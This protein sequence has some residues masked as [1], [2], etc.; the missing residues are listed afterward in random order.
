MTTAPCKN[1]TERTVSPNCHG[2]CK[3]YLDWSQKHRAMT[4]DLQKRSFEK[5]PSSFFNRR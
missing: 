2:T 3:R 1:C 4:K 5:T